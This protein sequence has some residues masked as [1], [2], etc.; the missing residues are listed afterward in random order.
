MS[1]QLEQ[2]GESS[3]VPFV[4][5]IVA[6]VFGC[7]PNNLAHALRLRA[8]CW[9]A[10]QQSQGVWNLSHSRIRQWEADN[11]IPGVRHY[12]LPKVSLIDRHE[13]RL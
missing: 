12:L 6:D 11:T 1:S 10:E 4:N 3:E 13:G 2:Q 5:G 8:K 7:H 9:M